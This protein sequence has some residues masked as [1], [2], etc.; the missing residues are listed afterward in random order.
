MNPAEIVSQD[1]LQ[2]RDIH[3]PQNPELWPPAPGWWML[4]IIVFIFLLWIAVRLFRYWKRYRLQKEIFS[5]L[6]ELQ[7]HSD[8]QTPQFLAEISVLLRRV[9]L[10]KFPRQQVAALTGKHWLSF[11]D[12]HGGGGEYSNGVGSV[13]AD[14]P[15]TR[16]SEETGKVDRDALLSLT[17]KWIKHNTYS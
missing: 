4:A 5:S 1:S 9:A 2:L 11:L 12:L 7:Q 14:G 10:V 3:L 16:Y 13:L 15:Y 17:R 6:D 8:E